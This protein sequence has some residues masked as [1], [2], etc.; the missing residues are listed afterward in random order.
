MASV[1]LMVWSTKGLGGDTCLKDDGT[2]RRVSFKKHKHH[3]QVT[4]FHSFSLRDA[5]VPWVYHI[6]HLILVNLKYTQ[7]GTHMRQC[8]SSMLVTEILF[9]N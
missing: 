2:I 6:C 5:F 7:I 3:T 8:T 4:A 1:L 9:V